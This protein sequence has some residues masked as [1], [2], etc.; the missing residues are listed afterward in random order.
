MFWFSVIGGVG[1]FLMILLS[2][3]MIRKSLNEEKVQFE[4]LDS[5]YD[6]F[7]KEEFLS[8]EADQEEESETL[9]LEIPSRE[10][11]KKV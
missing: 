9:Q 1:L 8:L 7:D 3:M 2:N 6:S 11:D 5:L 4:D 10:I